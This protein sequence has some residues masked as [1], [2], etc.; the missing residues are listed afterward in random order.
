VIIHIVYA[1]LDTDQDLNSIMGD[2][3]PVCTES[4]CSLVTNAG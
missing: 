2:S 1:H 4:Y 3:Y